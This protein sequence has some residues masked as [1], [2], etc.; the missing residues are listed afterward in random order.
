MN[1]LLKYRSCLLSVKIRGLLKNISDERVLLEVRN[2]E[3]HDGRLNIESLMDEYTSNKMVEIFSIK[4]EL[5]KLRSVESS[6]K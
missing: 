2:C 5:V 3:Y 6:E 1:L 4:R